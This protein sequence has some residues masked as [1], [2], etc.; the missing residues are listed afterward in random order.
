MLGGLAYHQVREDKFTPEEKL[1]L[2]GTA[3]DAVVENEHSPDDFTTTDL[4]LNN[5]CDSDSLSS[6]A[7]SPENCTG[8]G[9]SEQRAEKLTDDRTG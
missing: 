3:I 9:A 7:L 5:L 4:I 6:D 1:I 2:I 8:S